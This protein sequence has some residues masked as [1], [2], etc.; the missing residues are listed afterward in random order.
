[1]FKGYVPVMDR[2]FGRDGVR[3]VDKIIRIT[4]LQFLFL[5]DCGTDGL[6]NK[7]YMFDAGCAFTQLIYTVA[8]IQNQTDESASTLFRFSIQVASKP[9][10]ILR[11]SRAYYQ[12]V[13]SDP[14]NRLT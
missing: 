14:D 7:P 12:H 5:S 9:P 6:V 11:I 8:I 10:V 3:C 1:M 13:T 4:A 2:M